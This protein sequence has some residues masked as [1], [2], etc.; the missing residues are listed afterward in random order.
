M[1]RFDRP[2]GQESSGAISSAQVIDAPEGFGV[3]DLAWDIAVRAVLL[4]VYRYTGNQSF[5]RSVLG[6]IEADFLTKG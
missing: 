1:L 3:K 6:C 4:L 2:P 5:G